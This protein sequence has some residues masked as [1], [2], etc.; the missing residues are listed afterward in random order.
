ML[1]PNPALL[2]A[3]Q[4]P[5]NAGLYLTVYAALTPNAAVL[6]AATSMICH[7]QQALHLPISDVL[8]LP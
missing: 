1:A 7:Q 4:V 3:N 6:T 5:A 8:L 2:N